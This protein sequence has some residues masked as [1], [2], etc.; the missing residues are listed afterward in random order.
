M[1]PYNNIGGGWDHNMGVNV[2]RGHASGHC[3]KVCCLAAENCGTDKLTKLNRCL[4][5]KRKQQLPKSSV[6]SVPRKLL[7]H[8]PTHWPP[9]YLKAS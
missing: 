1:T 5:L 3:W 6:M 2:A 9:N 4:T 7:E 8:L